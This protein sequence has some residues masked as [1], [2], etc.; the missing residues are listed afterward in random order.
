MESDRQKVAPDS[1]AQESVRRFPQRNGCTA[2][3]PR[4]HVPAKPVPRKHRPVAQHHESGKQQGPVHDLR[5]HG[6]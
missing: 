1:G 3:L 4:S 6:H 5:V 2:H